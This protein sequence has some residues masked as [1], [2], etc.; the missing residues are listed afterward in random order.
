M[1]SQRG[2]GRPPFFWHGLPGEKFA[3][4]VHDL[5]AR[6]RDKQHPIS[7]ANA[8]GILL[9]KRRPEFA[10]LQKWNTPEGIRYLE[11]QI[12]KATERW[13]PGRGFGWYSPPTEPVRTPRRR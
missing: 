3:N 7:T 13:K 11:Q 1:T 4:A 12:K 10:W 2:R 8:I 5:Q 6:H 9:N